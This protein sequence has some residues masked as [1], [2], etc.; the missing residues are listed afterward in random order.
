VAA[1]S[2]SALTLLA[3]CGQPSNRLPGSSGA[4]NALPVGPPLRG[5]QLIV[6]VRTDPRSFNWY[7]QHD[8]TTLLV[9]YLTQA[10]L[11][12]VNRATEALEPWLAESWTVEGAEGLTYAVTLRPDA[13][14]SDGRPLTADDVVFSLAAAYEAKGSLLGDSLEVSGRRLQASARDP[15][16][17]VITFPAPFGPGLRLLDSLP[18]LPKHRLAEAVSKGTFVEAWSLGAP[19]TDIV[20]LGPFMLEEYVPSQR[21]SFVR[22]PH[23]FRKDPQGGALPYLDRLVVQIVPDQNTQILQLE[24]GQID[25]PADEA[26][27]EDYA[28]LKRA[29]DGGRLQLI[30]LGVGLDPPSF[31][32]NLKPGA[33]ADD[34]RAAWIQ[35][36]ELRQAISLAVD[37]QL[38]ADT[39]YY[40]AAI[41]VFG[42][43]TEANKKWFAT[44]APPTVHDPSRAKALL[45]SIGLTDRDGNDSLEDRRGTPAR[46]TLLTQKGQTA[47]ERG[48]AVIRDELKKI[49]LAVDV[50]ALEGNAL[51]TRFL[52]GKDY[53]A[54]YFLFYQSDTDPAL[55][56]DYW[57]SSGNSRVWNLGQTA[58]ATE[59]ERRMDELMA[60]Q[61]ASLDLDERKRLF[62]QVQQIFA[63][64]LP[65]VHF[66]APRIFVA[67]SAR[68][69]N[70]TPAPSR[71]Q[72]L[73]APDTIAVRR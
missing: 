28:T 29:A 15:R 19:I 30:D 31:W 62:D 7:T 73:W 9:S 22:N 55:N 44:G 56:L 53:D 33:F 1:L 24:A 21:L 49:G 13:K 23:Y 69:V 10:R 70:L 50:V 5:G 37:R 6:A 61:A 3:A 58:P 71:P 45:A 12:R 8:A 27:P 43:V 48:A 67:A 25:M 46:F 51:F 35:R 20:G 64:H 16:T 63:Q 17:V 2:L 14:F 42:P 57:L 41:P 11:V 52:T 34:A 39:V 40:G 72:V 59:W 47:L 60:R 68:V 18:I 65:I 54:V 38:F 26:R 4:S 36:D 32:M 66:A